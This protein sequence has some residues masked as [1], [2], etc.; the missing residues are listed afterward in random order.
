[1]MRRNVIPQD[2]VDKFE[3]GLRE[4]GISQA[5]F[6]QAVHLSPSFISLWLKGKRTSPKN[7]SFY[8]ELARVTNM[9]AQ[10]L[11]K[12]LVLDP[13]LSGSASEDSPFWRGFLRRKQEATSHLASSSQK[14]LWRLFANCHGAEEFVPTL[15]EVLRKYCEAKGFEWI[16]RK[17]DFERLVK[18]RHK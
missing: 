9:N 7:S 13:I 5:K 12:Q 16:D 3:D 2:I 11:M 18:D 10:E 15:E 17:E 1:M 4:K 6:A 14:R 8:E